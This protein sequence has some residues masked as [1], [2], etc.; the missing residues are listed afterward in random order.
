MPI[1]LS[2]HFQDTEFRCPCRA[3]DCSA[4]TLPNPRLIERLETLRVVVGKPIVI[5]SGIRCAAYNRFVGGEEPSAHLTG[6][7]ADLAVD[8]SRD[9]YWLLRTILQRDLFH[10]IG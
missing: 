5:T 1:Q 4:P 9:V 10:R 8:T 2:P 3:D 6:D 7:A